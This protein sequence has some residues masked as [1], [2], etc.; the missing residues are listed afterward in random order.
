MAVRDPALALTA[1]AV[2]IDIPPSVNINSGV[3]IETF[4]H[5]IALT[6][7]W[8]PAQGMP[9]D[10][11]HARMY[12]VLCLR[13][14]PP[15]VCATQDRVASM[16]DSMSARQLSV[17]LWSLGQIGFCPSDASM[18]IITNTLANILKG[19]EEQVSSPNF[20]SLRM[21]SSTYQN[22]GLD[23]VSGLD[24]RDAASRVSDC[25]ALVLW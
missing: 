2:Q 16:A 20:K 3:K 19:T 1:P 13:H 8:N 18:T 15:L 4:E 7:N 11:P 6:V 25:C 17:V 22:F 9:Y 5:H 23:A 12:S 24:A 21:L 14:Q 10:A